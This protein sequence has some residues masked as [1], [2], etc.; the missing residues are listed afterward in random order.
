MMKKD[1]KVCSSAVEG[2][3][4]YVIGLRQNQYWKDHIIGLRLMS[5]FHGSL[6]L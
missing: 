2:E 3:Q 6:G 1:T 4:E 5:S